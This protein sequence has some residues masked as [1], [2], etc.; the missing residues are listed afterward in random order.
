M[1][2]ILPIL[3]LM[4]LLAGCS[5]N[6]DL[7]DA[8]GNFEV[9]DVMISAEASGKLIIFKPEEG[10]IMKK[11]E[12]VAV[13]DSTD[14]SLKRKQMKAQLASVSSKIANINAQIDVREQ[15]KKNLTTDKNRVEKLMKDGAATQKQMDDITGQLDVVEKE[16]SS[17]KTQKTSVQ[18]EMQALRAQIAQV[19][20]SISKCVIKNPL[21]GVVLDKYAEPFE[22]TSFGKPLYKIANLDEMTLRVYVSGAQLPGIK[23]GQ[24]VEVLVDQNENQLRK[25]T[26]KI[27]WISETAE[28]TPKII[29]TREERVNLVYAVKIRVK[30]D[31]SLKI[32]MP[33][34]VNFKQL[35]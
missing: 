6:N 26:G 25:L 13:I 10:K 5:G 3:L 2:T 34:E 24:E 29:Q 14:L 27:T 35:N 8:Y 15:Q 23:I 28:F 1:K 16:I 20:E 30:N 31:G 7:S 18:A 4:V 32:G 11:G 21:K 19:E 9:N 17:V 33:G 12:L 22:I